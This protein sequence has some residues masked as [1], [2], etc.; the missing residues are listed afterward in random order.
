MEGSSSSS[1]KMAKIEL[2][3]D[4]QQLIVPNPHIFEINDFQCAEVIRYGSW[5]DAMQS[6]F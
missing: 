6:I 4:V 3:H 1:N 2:Q 5:E